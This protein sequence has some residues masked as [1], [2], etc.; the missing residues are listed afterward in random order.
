MLGLIKDQ[1]RDW[2]ILV[3]DDEPDS[4]EVASRWL[5][6]SGA[7]TLTASNGR[8]GL[9]LLYAHQPDCVIADL[10]MPEIDG[11]ELLYIMHQ[12]ATLA[13]IP[14]IA[15]TAHVMDTVKERVDKVGFAAYISKPLNPDKFV[16]QVINILKGG[17]TEASA[18]PQAGD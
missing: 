18:L 8:E 14:V 4:L 7:V 11:W 17:R 3:V 5:R 15:L 6:L 12:D 16:I 10:S 13:D 9:E 2:T 1:L